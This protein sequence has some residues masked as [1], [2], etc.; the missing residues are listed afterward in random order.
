MQPKDNV[1]SKSEERS[2][3]DP[4]QS[5]MRHFWG[6]PELT[7]LGAGGGQRCF[8]GIG[9]RSGQLAG[10]AFFLVRLFGSAQKAA[11]WIEVGIGRPRANRTDRMA[12]RSPSHGRRDRDATAFA[13]AFAFTIC[14]WGRGGKRRHGGIKRKK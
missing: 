10:E 5:R 9:K 12:S 3:G 2:R 6:S 7:S 11:G 1:R 13:F 14:L 4:S 8:L